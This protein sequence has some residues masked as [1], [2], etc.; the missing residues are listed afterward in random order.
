M[1]TRSSDY[2]ADPAFADLFPRLA[3]AD[4]LPALRAHGAPEGEACRVLE[5]LYDPGRQIR[6]AYGVGP[7][8]FDHRRVWP[9]GEVFALHY[10]VRPPM[11]RR[12]K[13]VAL[14]PFDVELYHFPN[15]RRLRGLRKFAG[16]ERAAEVWQTWIDND[17]PGLSLEAES[18][19]R[20]LLRYVPEQK[21][22]I[23]LQGRCT[24]THSNEVVKRAIS[25][26][27][28]AIENCRALQR[29][30]RDLRRASRVEDGAFR[31]QKPVA[32][33]EEHGL[34]AMR[35]VWGNALVDLL[36]QN[37]VNAVMER[38]A[39]GLNALHNTPLEHLDVIKAYQRI[40]MLRHVTDD[41]CAGYPR[42]A[43][44]VNH[45]ISGALTS[46]PAIPTQRATLHNDFHW[47]Q[48][49]GRLDRMTLLDLERCQLGDPLID[50]ATFV[51]E[52]N[53]LPHRSGTGVT[54][55]DAR[56]WI[57]AF[58]EAWGGVTGAPIDAARLRW[59]AVGATM[60][61]ARGMMRHLRC[62][63]PTI[64][65]HCLD[66]ASHLLQQS[67]GEVLT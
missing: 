14:G 23:Q 25:V 31:F 24:A 65:D 51:A 50:V 48:I 10:P 61:L 34:L 1:L 60:S 6:L 3:P 53:M 32:L 62:G 66:Q 16:R 15:D 63:W 67:C 21:W 27:S 54:S 8:D 37:P 30:A 42:Q 49:R 2:P 33:D 35:W 44:A 59:Y 45:V 12:G 26:R 11:S 56:L 19:R 17:E 29:R 40:T 58:V 39:R 20:G 4:I 43:G 7:V 5:A 18:L 57:K 38:V 22:I 9:D 36:R 13:V 47:N 64:V 55:E 46:V 41:L 52:I 28:S